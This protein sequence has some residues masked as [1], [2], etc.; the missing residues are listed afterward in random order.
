LVSLM[1]MPSF[2]FATSL[3]YSPYFCSPKSCK[4]CASSCLAVTVLLS[5]YGLQH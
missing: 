5:M 1:R 2:S 3:W 4:L